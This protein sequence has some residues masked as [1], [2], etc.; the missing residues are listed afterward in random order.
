MLLNKFKVLN[1]VDFSLYEKDV[2]NWIEIF[3]STPLKPENVD[4]TEPATG[5]SGI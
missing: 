2:L 4:P 3:N 5:Y 1:E